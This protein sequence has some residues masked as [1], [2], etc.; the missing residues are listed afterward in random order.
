VGA[1]A[2]EKDNGAHGIVEAEVEEHDVRDEEDRVALS[3]DVNEA[4]ADGLVVLQGASSTMDKNVRHDADS[5]KTSTDCL[6]DLDLNVSGGS[7]NLGTL[8]KGS[9]GGFQYAGLE[10][11][12]VRSPLS[13]CH[14]R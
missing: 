9:K 2:A 11:K 6:N 14:C 12:V 7:S 13:F 1:L 4:V 10:E 3:V 5:V 8:G